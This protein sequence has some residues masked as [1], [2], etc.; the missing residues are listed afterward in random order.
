MPDLLDRIRREIHE[1]LDA[2]RAAVRE[3]AQLE[4][5]LRALGGDGVAGRAERA[6]G[7]ARAARWSQGR[8]SRS[9]EGAATAA[10]K[11]AAP[12]ANRDAVF[13]AV[14]QRPGASV[15]EL[16][17]A[18][19]LAKNAVYVVLRRLIEQGDVQ[20]RELPSGRIG[21]AFR[22]K[23]ETPESRPA[24][25]QSPEKASPAADTSPGG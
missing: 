23:V 18:C 10:A 5:A 22:E 1:R 15:A 13:S 7:R 21:Y 9:G 17:A 25:Q 19:G 6:G 14:R 12:G 11:R 4:A 8:R 2:S 20:K 24:P 16:A 3:Y